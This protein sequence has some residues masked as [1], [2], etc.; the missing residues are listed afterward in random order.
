MKLFPNIRS[1]AGYTLVE[2]LGVLA[3]IVILA[4]ITFGT[5]AGIQSARMK[6]IA[7]AEIALIT[8]S[9]S[10]FHTKYGDYP[11]T[12]GEE[13]NAITL[14]KALLGWKVFQGNP[15]QMVDRTNVPPEGVTSFIDL[16]KILY[17]GNLPLFETVIPNNVQFIDPWGQPYVYAYKETKEWDNFSF[18]LYSKGPDQSHV[19]L[20][21]NGV[22]STSY[23]NLGKN[24]DNIY[25][26]D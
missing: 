10:R 14:S 3:V 24:I 6:S 20:E 25:L 11:I 18:V 19:Q 23:K 16:S 21:A 15:V 22:L 17:K 13:N 12:K 9:L 5:V 26:E 2:V 8:Q 7:K 4:G 1:L